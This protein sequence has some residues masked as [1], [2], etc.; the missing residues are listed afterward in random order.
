M[1][2]NYRCYYCGCNDTLG[3]KIR[4]SVIY[5]LNMNKWV[6]TKCMLSIPN[7]IDFSQREKYLNIKFEEK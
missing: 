4:G 2:Y 1:N 7:Y 6:C 3:K 5:R